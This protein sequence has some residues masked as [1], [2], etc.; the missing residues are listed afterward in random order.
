MNDQDIAEYLLT[1]PEFFENHAEVLHGIR[2]TSPHGVRAVSLQERQIEVQ[3]EK[4][5]QIERRLAELVRYGHENDGIS[6]KM[7]LWTLQVLSERDP[8]AVPGA[9]TRGLR[10][11][12][13]VPS[14][15]LRVWQVAPAYE[16]ADFA[17]SVSEEVRIFANSLTVPYCGENSGFEA[18]TWLDDETPA[19]VAL[20]A[21]RDPTEDDGSVF[22]LL[23][24]GSPDPRR[25]HE[26]MATDFLVQIGQL[27]SAAL[28]RLR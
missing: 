7:H 4:N 19:S 14:A 25:F 17:R 18:V 9:M 26:G 22:G 13:D 28:G 24:M 1:H 23:V 10:E 2:L 16:P 11:I 12:F 8:H 21:L 3:R 20:L 15:A 27:A 5:K 6:A